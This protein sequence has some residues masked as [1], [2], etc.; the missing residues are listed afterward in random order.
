MV[1]KTNERQE[2]CLPRRRFDD[3]RLAD[4]GGIKVN[5]GALFCRLSFNIEI[6]EFDYVSNKVG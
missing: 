3:G 2:D 5:I 6:E 4:A 1:D